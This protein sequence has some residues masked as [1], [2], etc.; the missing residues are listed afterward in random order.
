MRFL[1]VTQVVRSLRITLLSPHNQAKEDHPSPR[2]CITI[3]PPYR[4]Q[5]SSVA[6]NNRSRSFAGLITL[7]CVPNLKSHFSAFA[8]LSNRSLT[9]TIPS[10]ISVNS[11]LECNR[12]PRTSSAAH[13]SNS[14]TTSKP[15]PANGITTRAKAFLAEILTAQE[16]QFPSVGH[17]TDHRYKGKALPGTALARD[18]EVI[19]AAFF[20]L[21]DTEQPERMAFYR[22]RRWHLADKH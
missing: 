13:A 16:R 14:T 10:G 21:D 1:P 20:R 2:P 12:R 4:C 7:A 15:A 18:N 11:W 22:H 3:G 8:R 5:S 17:G 19:H 9:R 6:L